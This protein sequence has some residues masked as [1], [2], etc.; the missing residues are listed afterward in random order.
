MKIIVSFVFGWLVR[1]LNLYL[2]LFVTTA[3]VG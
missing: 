1:V 2:T 3:T